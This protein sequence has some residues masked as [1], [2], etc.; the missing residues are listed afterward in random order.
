MLLISSVACMFSPCCNKQKFVFDVILSLIAIHFS[1]SSSCRAQYCTRRNKSLRGRSKMETNGVQLQFLSFVVASASLV[2][3]SESSKAR[4][5]DNSKPVLPEKPYFDD[6]GPRNVSAV[7]GQST[8]LSCRVKH[9]G[10]RTVSKQHPDESL[11]TQNISS[12]LFS[13]LC[14]RRCPDF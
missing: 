12:F 6:V 13:V 7:V 4:F 8:L 2:G 1:R 5:T 14:H 9:P 11:L 10:D 3:I